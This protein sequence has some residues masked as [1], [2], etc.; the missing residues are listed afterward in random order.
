[1]LR[2][3]K[4]KLEAYKAEPSLFEVDAS[5]AEESESGSLYL[6]KSWEGIH[7]LLT[8]GKV[9]E[10]EEPLSLIMFSGQHFD[11]EQDMGYGPACYLEQEQVAII[12]KALSIWDEARFRQRFIPE[13]ME[14]AEIYPTGWSNDPEDQF[15]YLWEYFTQLKTFYSE[16]S[17][18]GQAIASYIG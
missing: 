16:A 12:A 1:M 2:F 17:Q 10:G 4:A 7:Y 3:S 5:A 6:D 15:Q 14:A 9:G 11:E 18:E 8:G 13:E